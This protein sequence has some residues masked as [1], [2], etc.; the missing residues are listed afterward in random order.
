[1]KDIKAIRGRYY[2]HNLIQEG[3]HEHQD[4]KFAI[5]DAAKIAH[6]ISAFANND[7]GR[8]LV[9]VRD[10]GTVAGV[11]SEEDIYMIEQAAQLYC[12]PAQQV[13]VTAFAVEGGAVVVRAVI[14]KAV[15][16]PV[17]ARDTDGTWRAYFRVK[18]E[19]IVVPPAMLAAWKRKSAPSPTLLSFTAA[20]SALLAYLDEWGM[21]SLDEYVTAA[22]ISVATATDMAARLYAM[23]IIDF[24]YTGAGFVVVR[25]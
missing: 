23:D 19:N 25:K 12:R 9:G 2:I 4:F 16:R 7:G 13:E 22:H 18:D 1:M 17:C 3:E 6:S 21:A 11:R 8:L 24:A 15:R 20:E 10:N 14:P 5:S